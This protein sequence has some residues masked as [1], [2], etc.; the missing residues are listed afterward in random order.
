[1]GRGDQKR[2]K[3]LSLIYWKKKHY[4]FDKYLYVQVGQPMAKAGVK[5]T[6][7]SSATRL[8]KPFSPA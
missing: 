7:A 4:E 1:M 8:E 2:D 3:E 6:L 5:T